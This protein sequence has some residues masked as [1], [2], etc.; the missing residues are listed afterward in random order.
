MREAGDYEL[1]RASLEGDRQA[2]TELLCRYERPV[3]NVAL[4]M[5]RSPDEAQDVAQTTFLKAFENLATY[6][7]SHKFYSWIYRIA[8]NESINALRRSGR[9]NDPL[10]ERL[11]SP[12]P[13]PEELVAAQQVGVDIQMAIDELT[14]EYRAVI[15]LKY[16]VECSYQ[17]I[18]QILGLEEK[19]VKSRLFTARQRLKDLLGKPEGD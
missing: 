5:L 10:E 13:G 11:V 14:P 12:Q 9:E 18:G 15:V 19:T 1:V 8:I 16:F 7:A 4:R 2:F 17:D 3:Y 6:D